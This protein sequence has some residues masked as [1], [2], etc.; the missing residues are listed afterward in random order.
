M[1]TY[2]VSPEWTSISEF[3]YRGQLVGFV[4]DLMALMRQYSGLE[5]S[6]VRTNNW[7]ETQNLLKIRQIDF[8]PAITPTRERGQFALFTP[9]YLFVDRVVIGPKRSTDIADISHLRGKRVGIVHGSVDKE[10]LASIGAHPVPVNNDNR[11]LELLD[12]GDA[13]YVLLSM[14]SMNKRISE[15]YQIVYAGKDLRLPVAM[16]VRPDPML[17]RILT[18]A[19]YAIPPEEL[20]KWRNAGSP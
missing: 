15:R 11:L 19:L 13:D 14:P 5:F 7:S 8:I 9:G 2:A 6:L 10:L 18:K 3:N 4:A 20:E 17:Q 1:L 12:N 16:A